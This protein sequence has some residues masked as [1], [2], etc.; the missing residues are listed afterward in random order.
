MRKTIIVI[1]FGIIMGLL[2]LVAATLAWYPAVIMLQPAYK[3]AKA[4]CDS[5]TVGMTYVDVKNKFEYLFFP[6]PVTYIDEQGGGQ[7]QLR[8]NVKGLDTTCIIM[9]ENG[10]VISS[11]MA[12][13]WL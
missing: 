13:G 9:F 6:E 3:D 7:V 10:K 8:N 2:I 1:S 11:G 4:I 5:I 12:Y